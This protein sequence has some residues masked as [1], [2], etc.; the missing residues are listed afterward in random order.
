ML[1]VLSLAFA[2]MLLLCVK[3]NVSANEHGYIPIKHN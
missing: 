1:L 3:S 2:T